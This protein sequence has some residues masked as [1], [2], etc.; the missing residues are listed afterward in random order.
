MSHCCAI[1]AVEGCPCI[2][3]HTARTPAFAHYMFPLCACAYPVGYIL[4]VVTFPTFRPSQQ[5]SL[6]LYLQIRIALPALSESHLR[7][8][9]TRYGQIAGISNR[10]G[11]DSSVQLNELSYLSAPQTD[12]TH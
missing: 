3:V 4:F 8:D 7:G 5:S 11:L 2:H 9:K 12:P 10:E 6:S 1:F